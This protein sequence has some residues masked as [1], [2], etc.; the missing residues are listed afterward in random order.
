MIN[1]INRDFNTVSYIGNPISNSVMFISKKVE[2]LLSNLY[3]CDNCLIF[4][5]DT[6]SIPDDLNKNHTFAVSSNPQLDY[7]K[8][9]N[10]LAYEVE[11]K[12][13]SRKYT[14]A[15][16]GYYVGENVTIG[17]YTFIEPLC[18]IDHD[19]VIGENAR[20]YAGVKIKNAII[21]NDFIANED[22]V[23]GTNGFSL[24]RDENDNLIRIPTLGKVIIGN[25]VEIGTL[26]TISVG[27]AG[28]TVINDYVKIDALVY[29][30]HDA[31]LNNNVKIPAG[32]I[33]G[34]YDIIDKNAS[35]GFNS[36]MRNRITIGENAIVGMGSVVT[37]SV[38]PNTTVVGNPAKLFD[39]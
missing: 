6:I 16:G 28:N 13:K 1:Q 37:K 17:K 34:G 27:S 11:Q 26:T 31:N 12:R 10:Q 35:F 3:L 29:I 5:E 32:V 20:I 7:A 23:I 30:G 14:L 8:Y 9:V 24:T 19:V 36:T 4:C 25:N 18:L 15:E 22:A 39:K 33:I 2:Y 38:K 21:G